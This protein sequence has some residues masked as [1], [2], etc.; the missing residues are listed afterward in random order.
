MANFVGL[1]LFVNTLVSLCWAS[2]QNKHELF[3]YID[4]KMSNT[5]SYTIRKKTTK[6]STIESTLRESKGTKAVTMVISLMKCDVVLRG[7]SH[8]SALLDK[9]RPS[10]TLSTKPHG[11]TPHSIV[12][13]DPQ[14]NVTSFHGPKFLR[15]RVQHQITSLLIP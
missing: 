12:S 13:S 1:D 9:A 5:H 7:R 10:E 3:N 11:V 14:L 6:L 2:I 8:H 4:L 15:S